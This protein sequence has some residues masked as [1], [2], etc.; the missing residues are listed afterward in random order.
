MPVGLPLVVLVSILG[1]QP[2]F[3]T[4]WDLGGSHT[5]HLDPHLCTSRGGHRIG[6]S[7]RHLLAQARTPAPLYGS[8]PLSFEAND[9]QTDSR[10]KFYA[11]GQGYTVFLGP[12]E[13]VLSMHSAEPGLRSGGG[14]GEH[15]WEPRP[16]VLRIV[17]LG[18]KPSARV[19]GIEP[20]PGKSSYFIGN[21]PGKWRRG[22]PTYAQ[23]KCEAV[24]PGIDLVYYGNQGRLEFD[25][26]VAPGA[27]V[28]AVRF[29]VR[30]AQRVAVNR[31]GELVLTTR[32]GE[33]RLNA[34]IMYQAG[35][36]GRRKIAGGYRLRNGREVSFEVAA[37]DA[38]QPL[39]IDPVLTYST[40]FGGGNGDSG[41]RIATDS[42]GSAYVVGSTGSLDYPV[43]QPLQPSHAGSI[44]TF[45][46]KLNPAGAGVVYSTYL[47]GRQADVVRGLAVD[48]A[49]SAYVVGTTES[50]DF[51]ATP[52]AWRTSGSGFAAKLSGRGDALVYSTLLP[53]VQ[54]DGVAVGRDGTAYV[55]GSTASSSLPTTAGVFQPMPGGSGDAF[56]MKLNATGSALSYCTYLGG[57]GSDA[58]LAIAVD[59][60]GNAYITGSTN[61]TDFRTANGFQSGYRGSAIYRS[62]NGG[63][64]WTAVNSGLSSLAIWSLAIDFRNPSII[65]AGGDDGLF[66]TT[67]GGIS[68]KPIEL[69]PPS[70]G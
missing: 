14:T 30:G 37:Y 13:A 24:Y 20:L 69:L 46:A 8:L 39:F 5:S 64:N 51:P 40:Y 61:S 29:A 15:G 23:V 2:A 9:G 57:A 25:F 50:A 3:C 56:V 1:V 6:V 45:I 68:W 7:E 12:G 48:S 36:A 59:S 19:K 55:T 33:V 27:D 10:V 52:G 44:D 21:D 22:V 63:E 53:G 54:P 26:V 28:D 32:Q 35:E 31:R 41:Y 34:P 60:S 58:G 38:R 4:D 42:S 43:W 11:R 62:T 70:A 16:A 67:N 65:Y 49:G 18:A 17:L 47:G 66:Q